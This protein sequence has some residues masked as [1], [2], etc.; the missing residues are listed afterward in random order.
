MDRPTSLDACQARLV[1][2][3][4]ATPSEV[5]KLTAS[6]TTV[7]GSAIREH[8]DETGIDSHSAAC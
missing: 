4:E 5:P 3:H 8:G 2:I 6:S 1:G 7:R